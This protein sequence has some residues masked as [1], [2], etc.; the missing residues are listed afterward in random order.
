VA[1][2]TFISDSLPDRYQSAID[3]QP[4][5][6]HALVVDL[7]DESSAKEHPP[8]AVVVDDAP[9]RESLPDLVREFGFAPCTFSS[10]EKFLGSDSFSCIQCLILDIAIPGMNGLDLER[11]LKGRGE[12][13]STIFTSAHQD[14]A[15]RLNA[16]QR[17]ALEF[18]FKPFS[19]AALL[20]ALTRALQAT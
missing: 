20:D 10:A 6:P 15:V 13:I 8:V 18:L 17:G 4:G 5:L 9:V 7:V 11:E 12:R 3:A 1:G 2:S 14:E 19:D 16:I